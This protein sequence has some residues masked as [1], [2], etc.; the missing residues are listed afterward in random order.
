MATHPRDAGVEADRAADLRTDR[1]WLVGRRPVDE[2]SRGKGRSTG[3]RLKRTTKGAPHLIK[4]LL[5]AE[6]TAA[7]IS[8]TSSSTLEATRTTSEGA[9]EAAAAAPGRPAV[10][11]EGWP[12][13]AAVASW[14][15]KIVGS[16]AQSSGVAA[17]ILTVHEGV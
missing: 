4:A 16:L 15:S 6:S 11:A 7:V 8:R 2:T 5:A 12:S 10:S 13:A 3:S 14:A 17:L 9:S 1:R